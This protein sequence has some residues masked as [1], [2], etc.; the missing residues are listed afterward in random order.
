MMKAYGTRATYRIFAVACTIT[1]LL[2][3]LYNKIYL[4]KRSQV[5]N[6]LCFSFQVWEIFLRLLM[7]NNGCSMSVWLKH[8]TFVCLFYNPHILLIQIYFN[9]TEQPGA[10]GVGR[11]RGYAPC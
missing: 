5:R 2:Y 1:G 3:F 10:K 11:P 9:I 4:R 7:K 6:H 8:D